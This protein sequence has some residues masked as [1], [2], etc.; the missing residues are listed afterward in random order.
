MHVELLSYIDQHL[1]L[2]LSLTHFRGLQ[3]V[4][5]IE[6]VSHCN[7]SDLLEQKKREELAG[8]VLTP[9]PLDWMLMASPFPKDPSS[10]Y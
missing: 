6:V 2:S 5:D 10:L 8:K 7:H 3:W 4:H 9:L 1:S